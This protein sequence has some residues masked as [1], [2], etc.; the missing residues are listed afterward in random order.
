LLQICKHNS[1]LQ[2]YKQN[3]DI[4]IE[5]P[6]CE[7]ASLKS[8]IKVLRTYG[9]NQQ[10]PSNIEGLDN[11]RWKTWVLVDQQEQT[12]QLR[13]SKEEPLELD[14]EVAHTKLAKEELQEHDHQ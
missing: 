7:K 14:H 8:F 13:I 4:M 5:F 2:R 11:S 1:L 12:L 6:I 9:L 10:R 3:S